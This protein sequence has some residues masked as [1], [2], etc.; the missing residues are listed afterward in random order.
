MDVRHECISYMKANRECFKE[1]SSV[2]K[3]YIIYWLEYPE[4]AQSPK[5]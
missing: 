5:T 2:A 3:Q 1:V 4:E